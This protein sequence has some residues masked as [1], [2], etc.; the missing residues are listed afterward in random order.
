[1]TKEKASS[2]EKVDVNEVI[3]VFD[4][5]A[6]QNT[7]EK[8]AENKSRVP[9]TESIFNPFSVSL[10]SIHKPNRQR[11]ENSSTLHQAPFHR[12]RVKVNDHYNFA[13]NQFSGQNR[14]KI[15]PSNKNYDNNYNQS[16]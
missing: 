5:P 3:V 2:G 14:Q 6:Q 7:K 12:K 16:I 13:N 10:P 15:Y 1:M 11:K 9:D 8:D 4:K